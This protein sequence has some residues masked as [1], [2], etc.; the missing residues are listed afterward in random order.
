MIEDPLYLPKDT[1]VFIMCDA[2]SD[3][4]MLNLSHIK[5]R[6]EI[7]GYS[8]TVQYVNDLP[9]IL[10]NMSPE[11]IQKD[12]G[13]YIDVPASKIGTNQLYKWYSYLSVLRKARILKKHFLVLFADVSNFKNDVEIH[14]L[15]EPVRYIHDGHKLLMDHHTANKILTRFNTSSSY[16][17]NN[18]N[19]LN[20]DF[21]QLIRM[22]DQPKL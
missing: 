16:L 19:I 10:R 5:K 13:F 1:R 7:F 4:Q 12:M 17:Y 14:H 22:H 3:P 8:F 18:N 9:M 20:Y 15:D 21:H 2:N 11:D 6:L